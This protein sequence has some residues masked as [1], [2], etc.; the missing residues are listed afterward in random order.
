MRRTAVVDRP[1]FHARRAY[2]AVVDAETAPVQMAV[3]RFEPEG[4]GRRSVW[5]RRPDRRRFSWV[6]VLKL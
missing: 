1:D 4:R 2:R 6:R 5:P 3:F